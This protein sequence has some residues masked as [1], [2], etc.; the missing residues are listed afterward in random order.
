MAKIES[1]FDNAG[2]LTYPNTVTDA[3]YDKNGKKLSNVL[4]RA[5]YI[6]STSSPEIEDVASMATD[7]VTKLTNAIS[8]VSI[9]VDDVE[10]DILKK[11]NT[12]VF[13][14]TYSMK[15]WLS[16]PDNVTAGRI[17][18]SIYLKEED[19]P[20]Y[21]ICD[22]LSGPDPDTG[23]YFII[24]E[25]GAKETDLEK[26]LGNKDISDIGDG[27]ITG[28]ITNIEARID[29]K[30]TLETFNSYVGNMGA[31]ANLGNGTISNAIVN[32]NNA[33]NKATNQLKED[34][35]ELFQSVSD[36]KKLVA[37]AITDKGVPTASNATFAT[38]A[39]NISKIQVNTTGG[40]VPTV[41]TPST[42]L[43]GTNDKPNFIIL[44][45]L[46]YNNLFISKIDASKVAISI[47]GLATATEELD[48]TELHLLGSSYVDTR[49]NH[50]QFNT[51]S[52][53]FTALPELPYMFTY[54]SA[55][56]YQKEIHILGGA[57][58]KDYHYKWDGNAWT[59]VSTLPYKLYTGKA[60][61][62]NNEIHIL[63]G[64]DTNGSITRYNGCKKH[65]KWDGNTWEEVSTLPYPACDF[66]VA[67]IDNE[68]HIFG[69]SD[70]TVM[71]IGKTTDTCHYKFTGEKW[72]EV[73]T[74][75]FSFAN[76][77]CEIFNDH[78]HI[79]G[80]QRGMCQHAYYDEVN[81]EWNML[82]PIPNGYINHDSAYAIFNKELHIMGSYIEAYSKYHYSYD[83]T[84]WKV[85]PNLSYKLC[86]GCAVNLGL[87]PAVIGFQHLDTI[88]KG[89][90]KINYNLDVSDYSKVKIAT[91]NQ[92]SI[93][94]SVELDDITLS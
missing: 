60:I 23:F 17:G 43:T 85:L 64:I 6:E 79:I 53:A 9:R 93:P 73:S 72:V 21:W 41:T 10:S 30:M 57:Y 28:A 11:P 49:N 31:I 4:K 67:I 7:D 66:G 35:S 26:I 91:E 58:S 63:G 25:C 62:F 2:T 42:T 19:V 48:S 22:V 61:V 75:P 20:D 69:G 76:G 5:L 54:G 50:Y 88:P 94:L 84:S 59:Q 24:Q 51:A 81:N 52:N 92:T 77:V 80:G 29:S 89:T 82:D 16:N 56:C 90:I 47:S 12:H 71:G 3:V 14:D 27:T 78:V 18:D 86:G 87:P 38:M 1:L 8:N 39:D 34:I 46:N 13:A 55:V 83:G 70:S 32:V 45:T 36:G 37:N 40:S 68:I 44:D 33:L 65:Y 15:L 74:L